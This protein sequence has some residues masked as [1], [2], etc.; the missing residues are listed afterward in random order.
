MSHSETIALFKNIKEGPVILKLTRK[1]CVNECYYQINYQ[2]SSLIWLLSCRYQRTKS[3]D[4]E[5]D[6]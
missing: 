3:I 2:L 1:K 4:N 5:K 6:G